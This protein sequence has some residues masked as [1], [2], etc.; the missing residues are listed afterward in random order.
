VLSEDPFDL[1]LAD[2][3][4]VADERAATQ[5]VSGCTYQPVHSASSG[6]TLPFQP[7]RVRL[8]LLSVSLHDSV[9]ITAGGDQCCGLGQCQHLL[10][11]HELRLGQGAAASRY[12]CYTQC[13]Y[14]LSLC[15]KQAR[16]HG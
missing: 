14:G 7:L 6:S 10:R 9:R 11:H 1:A 3:V 2:V 16:L 15:R 4:A 12:L 13:N 5:A 8:D